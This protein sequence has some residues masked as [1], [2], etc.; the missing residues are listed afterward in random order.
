[1]T[2]RLRSGHPHGLQQRAEGIRIL[3]KN[4]SPHPATSHV[5]ILRSSL[6]HDAFPA[7]TYKCGVTCALQAAPEKMD[8][9]NWTRLVIHAAFRVSKQH[10]L[11]APFQGLLLVIVSTALAKPLTIDQAIA[12]AAEQGE[13]SAFT[14]CFRPD[15][16]TL[17]CSTRF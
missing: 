1:M 7:N 16:V 13:A 3:R 8:F 4:A 11:S 17:C 15:Q 12:S 14:I 5:L 10:A 2:Q 6:F 9:R